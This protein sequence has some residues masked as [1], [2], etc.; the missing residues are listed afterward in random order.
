VGEGARERARVLLV[1]GGAG[2]G[3]GGELHVR[4]V[5]RHVLADALGTDQGEVG[6]ADELV[7]R[8]QPERLGDARRRG[9]RD[10]VDAL[11]R[12][13][14]DTLGELHRAER[15]GAGQDDG[16]LVAADPVAAVGGAL[17]GADRLGEGLQALV[18]GLVAELVVGGLELV[19]VHDDERDGLAGAPRALELAGEV[20][21]E[22]A[23][24]AQ[25][26]ERVGH[27]DLR[28]ALDLGRAGGG[29]AAAQ[30][31]HQPRQEDEDGDAERERE[32]ARGQDVALNGAQVG[33]I[34]EAGGGRGARLAGDA[35]LEHAEHGVDL[36]V[37]DAQRAGRVAAVDGAEQ[38]AARGVVLALQREQR[39]DAA[40]HGRRAVERGRALDPGHESALGAGVVGA[41]AV[42][43]LEDVLAL[44][45]LLLHE[46]V[47]RDL[48]NDAEAV[49]GLRPPGEVRRP[50]LAHEHEAR[51]AAEHDKHRRHAGAK[52]PPFADALE[53]GHS[54]RRL[55]GSGAG[56]LT[57]RPSAAPRDEVDLDP[58]AGGERGHADRG[59][60]RQELAHVLGVDAVERLVLVLEP[61]QERPGRDDV[62][63]AEAG[64][65]EHDRQVVH[66]APRL[67]LDV[68]EDVVAGG[69]VG[70]DLPRD[71][72]E[73]ADAG[74]VA[75]GRLVEG[76]RRHQAFDHGRGFAA[77][78]AASCPAADGATR[79]PRRRWPV[80]PPAGRTPRR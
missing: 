70:G 44:D 52:G 50:A 29:E 61:G 67:G 3:V 40:A 53:N 35:V 17:G 27:S 64:R 79:A 46:P 16:E 69:R 13:R 8:A 72:Q 30:E 39:V 77:P 76:P 9:E 60:R 22:G 75:V 6:L 38:P 10:A 74:R 54:R 26:G 21:L 28:Q 71:E 7:A 51:E 11:A 32:R 12:E 42:G 68:A 34:G 47:V 24:V 66:D 62:P 25:A 63:Q 15:A 18:A 19:D 1:L 59:P 36:L 2:V 33:A 23:V 57:A 37:L 65:L 73:V 4:P 41:D 49:R 58:R 20:L 55:I 80:R 48:Q 5:D 56:D 14:P 78:G 31:E 43:A 45:G